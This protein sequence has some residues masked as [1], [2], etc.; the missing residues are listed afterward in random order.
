MKNES[1]FC[2]GSWFTGLLFSSIHSI[3]QKEFYV[4][5][6][7][8]TVSG[9]KGIEKEQIMLTSG[10]NAYIADFSSNQTDIEVFQFSLVQ[11]PILSSIH[12][13]DL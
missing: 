8:E 7:K 12:W 11:S 6:L 3:S 2:S 5:E 13:R 1:V 4:S 9:E 10:E